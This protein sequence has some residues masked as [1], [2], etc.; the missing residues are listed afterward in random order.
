MSAYYSKILQFYTKY[1][2]KVDK[3]K[4]IYNTP[5]TFSELILYTHLYNSNRIVIPKKGSEYGDFRPDRVAM[6]DATA[7][8][9]LLQ[10]MNSGMDK[11][12]IPASVHCDHLIT[13]HKEAGEDLKN[14][15]IINRE[16][17]D[18]LKNSSDKFGID[19]WRPGSGII[20]QIILENYAFPGGLIIG[21]DS[22]TPNAGGLGMLA[23]GVGGSDAVDVMTGLEWE[24]KMPLITGV[25]LTGSLSKWTSPKDVILHLLGKISVKGG[26]NNILEYFGD[27]VKSISATG[28]ATIC[29]MGAETGATTSIFP[30]DEKTSEYLRVTGREDMADIA[31]S[32]SKYLRASDEVYEYPEKYYDR[33]IEIDLALIEPYINGPCS[34]DV[35]TPIS[36]LQKKVVAENIPEKL[37]YA[38]LGSC[39]NS[40]FEDLSKAS[41]IASQLNKRDMKFSIPLLINPGSAL[42]CQMA[43]ES[44]IINELEKAGATIMAN[45]CGPCIGQW[46][47]ANADNLTENSV[48]T[49]FNRNFTKRVDGSPKTNIFVASAEITTAMAI[50][51][52]LLFNPISDDIV[53]GRG[54]LFKLEPPVCKELPKP[55]NINK[56]N[57]GLITP[58][59]RV[60]EI[61]I[62]P[63]SERLQKLAP[64]QAPANEEFRRMRLLGKIR[65]KCTT[66]HISMA[67]KWLK[68]RGHLENIS[69]NLLLGAVNYFNDCDSEKEHLFLNPL[70]GGYLSA[71]DLAR[72]YKKNGI[73]SIVIAEE[74][75]GEGSS[76]EHAAMEPR[77][78]NVKVILAKSFA[79]IHETN[80]KK[81][82]ILAL[83][84][85]NKCDY[86][87]IEES[88]I[89]T[90][91]NIC[92]L[93][94]EEPVTIKIEHRVGGN[95]SIMALHT[96]NNQQIEWFKA[97]SAL[98]YLKNQIK[99]GYGKK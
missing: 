19:F 12:A 58:L 89:I 43:K 41:S 87:K 7:Q 97:G 53:D 49:S 6:Q 76:R 63:N 33:V 8:M 18:F 91:E 93:T 17:Y 30:Y 21:T 66:D 31:D 38:L 44:G 92:N 1:S 48:I 2:H 77:F 50:N 56:E 68:F 54:G 16:V 32:F 72:F 52:S 25:K 55:T 85:E 65:G 13:A 51:G 64:F 46:N 75:Y 42:I 78:M 62:D 35:A 90:I 15:L 59:N 29:N 98:N 47:R 37:E 96:Y 95:E 45:A 84:F 99:N 9:A 80:L 28:R 67:G 94:Q 61:F 88:D 26:T 24:L 20:H 74:N 23:I 34:P 5:L 82:G 27:G 69:G 39:T 10:F 60:T 83:T 4:S 71:P 40:S 57:L 22:H 70:E 14:A 81:Q 73:F 86:D 79:R 11:C 3:L 36:V